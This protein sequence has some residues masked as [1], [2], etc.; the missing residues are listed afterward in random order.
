MEGSLIPLDLW[1]HL[2]APRL[3]V[4][5]LCALMQLSRASFALWSSDRCWQHQKRRVCARFPELEAL[6]VMHE[7]R[8]VKTRKKKSKAGWSMPKLGTWFVFTRF[9]SLGCD[10]GGFKALC[11]F[12]HVHGEERATALVF[13]IV[14]A[15]LP[16]S[17]VTHMTS[18]K[19]YAPSHGGYK[20][21][22]FSINGTLW[23]GANCSFTV[24]RHSNAPKVSCGAWSTK[25]LYDLDK[26]TEPNWFFDAWL[27]FLLDLPFEPYWSEKILA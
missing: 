10:M 12:A 2:I 1:L 20:S 7:T 17:I 4:R 15:H 6:F 24:V 21:I 5:E 9:L 13:A 11:W 25:E 26:F 19:L 14:K 18:W 23:G 27:Y 16:P 8:E 3:G 22:M